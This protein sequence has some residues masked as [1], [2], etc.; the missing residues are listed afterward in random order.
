MWDKII[1]WF[2]LYGNEVECNSFSTNGIPIINV[3]RK[4]NNHIYIGH[5]FR[6]NNRLVAN[7]IGYDSPCILVAMDNA[8]ITIG[9]EVGMSQT[10]IIAMGADIYIGSNT[11]FGG[12][13][14]IYSS[15]FHSLDYKH[16]RDYSINGLDHQNRKSAPVTIG[17][18]CFIGAGSIILKGIII[19]DLSIVGAG[20]VVTKSI[21]SGE[22]WAG[23]PARFVKKITISKDNLNINSI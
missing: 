23:N 1:T 19:G 2:V 4:G 16:R 20:S 17:H 9:E 7:Q 6:M 21:P 3:G 13:V 18:D 8:T 12:G 14:K 11:L 22:I 15:D 5:N 10:T